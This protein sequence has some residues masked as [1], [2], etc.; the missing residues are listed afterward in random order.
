MK[1]KLIRDT[2]TENSTTGKLYVNGEFLC[3]TLEDTVR[4]EKIKHETC[5]DEGNYKVILN[6]S[7]RFKKL[8]PLL[9]YVP[10][11]KGIRI[12]SGNTKADTSGC[13]L[14]GL[15][16]GKDYIGKSRLAF[17]KLMRILENAKDIEIEI[18][19]L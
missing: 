6:V 14:V 8:M 4:E 19:R 3:Y 16:R 10:K 2:F 17:M 12:H 18:I 11:F 15:T 1:L 9:L 5:I 13:I 7:N